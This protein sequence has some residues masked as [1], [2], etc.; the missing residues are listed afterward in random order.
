M[1]AATARYDW[2]RSCANSFSYLF[3]TYNGALWHSKIFHNMARLGDG[4]AS[5]TLA[6]KSGRDGKNGKDAKG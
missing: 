1:M 6:V 4:D 3:V 2:Q 5:W